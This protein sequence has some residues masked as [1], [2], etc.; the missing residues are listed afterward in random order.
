MLALLVLTLQTIHLA[1][2]WKWITLT[3]R[4]MFSSAI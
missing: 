3:T 1:R 2:H 4:K